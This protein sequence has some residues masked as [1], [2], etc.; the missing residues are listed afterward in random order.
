MGRV[1]T[2]LTRFAMSN[3]NAIT[4]AQENTEIVHESETS[5]YSQREEKIEQGCEEEREGSPI[6]IFLALSFRIVRMLVE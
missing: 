4:E 2:G 1:K 5:T 3:E 6:S